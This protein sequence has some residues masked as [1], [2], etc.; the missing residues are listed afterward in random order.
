MPLR[1]VYYCLCLFSL[2]LTDILRANNLEI[3]DLQL[4]DFQTISFTVSWDNSWLLEADQA[5]GNHDGVWLFAK[6]RTR[7]G[8]WQPLYFQAVLEDT[9]SMS[10]FLATIPENG[11][12][13]LVRRSKVGSGSIE[14]VMRLL[15]SETLTT[16]ITDIQLLAIE[17][18][19][20]PEGAFYVGDS[21]SFH[22][23]RGPMGGSPV[24]IESEAEIEMSDIGVGEEAT[25]GGNI[26]TDYPKGF[27]AFYVMKYEISQAQYRD[28]L[29]T[30]SFEQQLSR[31]VTSPDDEIGT[32][33]LAGLS[34][35]KFRNGIVISKPGV[36]GTEAA[37]YACDANENGMMN[38]VND[39][40]DR[41]CNFLNWRDILA[42]MDWAGLMPITEL[43]F[44]KACRGPLLWTAGEFAWGTSQILDANS[45]IN[46][47]MANEGVM[48]MAT[49]EAGLAS[50]GFQGL[51]GPL[52]CGFGGS[53]SSNRLQIGAGYFGAT[54][55]SGNLWE[56]CV[57]IREA[58]L[59]FKGGHGDG[60]LDSNGEADVV[61]WPLEDGGIHRGGAWNSGI[62][63]EFRDLAV[64]DRFFH[65]LHPS[66]RRNTTGGRGGL[67]LE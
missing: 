60:H 15:L 39:G 38:E 13:C 32:S 56:L 16:E 59:V 7:E 31:T 20:I 9:D 19:H 61:D 62:Q 48:E 46:D 67:I 64:S 1:A 10:S 12:G 65:D 57:S 17:M 8:I 11:R 40:S 43:A 5:P 51:Q 22:H 21:S 52:R 53:D 44:E 27:A 33:A 4:I 42:Y 41:S 25:I 58:G 66:Q 18:V 36:P 47:G 63:G 14:G 49:T 37:V 28:F 26:P 50:H 3:K 54:E 2:F 23:I 30:L 55:L 35:Q 45:L 6:V 29:N 34:V 24:L